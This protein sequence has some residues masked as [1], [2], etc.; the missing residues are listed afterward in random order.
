MIDLF[1]EARAIELDERLATGVRGQHT[2]GDAARGRDRRRL[3]GLGWPEAARIEPGALA[4]LVT[5]VARRRA[6]RRARRP[7]TR[8]GRVVFAATARATCAT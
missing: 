8:V 7:S 2:A 1:E 3:R 5:V 4:D 6:A